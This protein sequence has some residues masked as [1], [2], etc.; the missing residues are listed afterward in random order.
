MSGT[1]SSSTVQKQEVEGIMADFLKSSQL[2]F[3]VH[4]ELLLHEKLEVDF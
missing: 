2:K 1:S 4:Y 3:N